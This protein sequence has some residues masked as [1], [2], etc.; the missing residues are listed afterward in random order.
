MY[1]PVTEQG[2]W[3]VRTS[4]ELKKLYKDIDVM[5]DVR[6]GRFE[7]FGH[8]IKMGQIRMAKNVSLH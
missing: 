5:A 1:R 4:Q 2:V 8:V 6:R 7:W 3:I